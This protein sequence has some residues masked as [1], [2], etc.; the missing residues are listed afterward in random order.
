[1]QIE[2][3]VAVFGAGEVFGVDRS[4]DLVGLGGTLIQSLRQP[5][6]IYWHFC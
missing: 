2:P 5:I 1:M 3:S 4:F 6:N